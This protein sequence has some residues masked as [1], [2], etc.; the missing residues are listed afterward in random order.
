MHQGPVGVISA[1]LVMKQAP[2]ECATVLTCVTAPP[3]GPTLSSPLLVQSTSVAAPLLISRPILYPGTQ[4]RITLQGPAF[5]PIPRV[6]MFSSA[7]SAHAERQSAAAS[8]AIP[9]MGAVALAGY[10]L[11]KRIYGP[12]SLSNVFA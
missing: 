9:P 7:P 12:A 4:A 10:A 6:P 2:Q 1:I 11:S 8:A 3:L 5:L